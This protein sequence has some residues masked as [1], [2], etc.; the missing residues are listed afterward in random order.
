VEIG[1]R[2]RSLSVEQSTNASVAAE[3]KGYATMGERN[4][5]QA[6]ESRAVG[7]DTLE[8]WARGKIQAQLQQLLE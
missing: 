5:N 3:G 1:E 2:R 4:S 8:Q 7:Y 6:I